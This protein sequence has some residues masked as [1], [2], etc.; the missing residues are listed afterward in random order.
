[1]KRLGGCVKIDP[2]QAISEAVSL[3]QEVDAVV[4][5]AGLT[6][7]WE[8]EGFDRTSLALPGRQD[9]TI[10]ALAEAN[11]NIVVVIQAVGL[12]TFLCCKR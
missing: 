3:A 9:E 2:V 12:R 10:A 7:E 4:F 1:L 6:P 5:V 8:S 11:P